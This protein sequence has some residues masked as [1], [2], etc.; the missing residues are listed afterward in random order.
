MKRFKVKCT[1]YLFCIRIEFQLLLIRLFKMCFIHKGTF[2]NN[3]LFVANF[4][5]MWIMENT[6]QKFCFLGQYKHSYK[7]STLKSI[8]S[9]L[10]FKNFTK[11]KHFIELLKIIFKKIGLINYAFF[12]SL[13]HANSNF[14]SELFTLYEINHIPSFRRK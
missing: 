4:R 8:D 14:L 1:W 12:F 10:F 9:L 3:T 6:F 13:L 5:I 2:W 11:F 7:Q